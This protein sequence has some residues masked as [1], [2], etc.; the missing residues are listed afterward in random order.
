MK[1]QYLEPE[2]DVVRIFFEQN[3]LSGEDLTKREITDIDFWED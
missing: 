3:I 2:T 1:K